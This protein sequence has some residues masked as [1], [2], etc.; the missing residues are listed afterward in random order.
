[1]SV[2]K[3]L[4]ALVVASHI[5]HLS[6]PVHAQSPAEPNLVLRPAKERGSTPR[7]G[8]QGDAPTAEGTQTQSLTKCIAG[9]RTTSNK[10]REEWQRSCEVQ[11]QRSSGQNAFA[12]CIADWDAATH[13]SKQEWRNA[14]LRTVKD[15]PA[16]FR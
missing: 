12:V 9:W 5:G 14:C 8:L 4:S 13:M 15:D 3:W 11:N 6:V 2:A 10:T 1:V 16:A 7:M